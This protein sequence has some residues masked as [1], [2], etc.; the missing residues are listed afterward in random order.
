MLQY[1]ERPQGKIGTP[2]YF[3]SGIQLLEHIRDRD[4]AS[5]QVCLPL[6]GYRGSLVRLMFVNTLIC[7][8][9]D[10]CSLLGDAA[11]ETLTDCLIFRPGASHCPL[12]LVSPSLFLL[13]WP[14]ALSTCDTVGASRERWGRGA[15]I[16]HVCIFYVSALC[17]QLADSFEEHLFF[18]RSFFFPHPAWLCHVSTALSQ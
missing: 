18:R 10:L 12:P 16:D 4:T 1:L 11:L 7:L 8:S 14:P 17:S 3:Q 15:L 9:P 6:R 13:V 5:C 2:E